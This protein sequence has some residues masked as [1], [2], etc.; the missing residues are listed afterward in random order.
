MSTT[1][2]Y[3]LVC[4]EHRNR[5][6]YPKQGEFSIVDYNKTGDSVHDPVSNAAV[7]LYWKG[8]E[9]AVGD[10]AS[11]V[12]VDIVSSI[13][14]G[15]NLILEVVSR[16]VN[17]VQ[18]MSNYYS[19]SVIYN[20]NSGSNSQ[21]GRILKSEWLGTTVA[22]GA[23]DRMKLTLQSGI[24]VN[25]GD[26]LTISDSTSFDNMDVKLLFVPGG[27][28]SYNFYTTKYI[29][30]NESR[31]Q[32]S[33][34]TKYDGELRLLHIQ[35]PSDT[36]AWLV[37]DRYCLRRG[38]PLSSYTIQSPVSN[39]IIITDPL[40][41]TSSF[42]N[43]Y[44]YLRGTPDRPISK[45][46]N[47][48]PYQGSIESATATTIQ[49]EQQH[50]SYNYVGHTIRIG[51]QSLD[52]IA[53]NQQTHTVTV[54]GVG[55]T[56]TPTPGTIYT[57]HSVNVRNL[58]NIPVV[59]SDYEIWGYSYDNTSPCKVFMNSYNYVCCDVKLVHLIL[60]NVVI[61]GSF[62]GRLPSYPYLMVSLYNDN[63]IKENILQS[64]NPDTRT[65][66]FHVSLDDCAETT[67]TSFLKFKG[68]NVNQVLQLCPR[69]PL[70]IKIQLP[71]GTVYETLELDAMSPFPIKEGLQV[72]ALFQISERI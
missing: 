23:T 52:I 61:K 34:I 62:G 19:K 5:Q 48:L 6:K 63:N 28:D 29:L 56:V 12:E 24:I 55:F 40:I 4:S 18:Q 47:I 49:I 16:G 30:Y 20:N 17:R 71:D 7:E 1:N 11:S 15:G 70:V 41:D 22:A 21:I 35:N 13:T 42:N 14:Y 44:V 53:Y 66:A 8:S 33:N 64:N 45:I 54:S 39:S 32:Y 27:N 43:G 58:T 57:F 2:R 50:S 38:T 51:T 37:T 69:L 59:G 26:H 31:N 10:T 60:P 3:A 67:K 72:S 25:V 46:T 36:S 9:F 68:S 65:A